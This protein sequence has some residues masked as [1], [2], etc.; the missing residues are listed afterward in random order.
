MRPAIDLDDE[1]GIEHDKIDDV[2][3]DRVLPAELPT[4]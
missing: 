1:L 3:P 4:A 2:T